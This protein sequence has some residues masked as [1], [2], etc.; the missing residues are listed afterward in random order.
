MK[1]HYPYQ[2]STREFDDNLGD[3]KHFAAHYEYLFAV[4]SA[5]I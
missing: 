2:N 4:V 3:I 5:I 1:A